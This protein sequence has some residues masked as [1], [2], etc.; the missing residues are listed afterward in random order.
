M[1]AV[2]GRRARRLFAAAEPYRLVPLGDILHRR[3]PGAFVGAIAE[4][5]R[6]TFAAGAPP[7]FVAF[8]YIDTARFFLRNYGFSHS[9]SFHQ[10]E[11]TNLFTASVMASLFYTANSRGGVEFSQAKQH[12]TP[13][14]E[15]RD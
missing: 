4:R 12:I 6:C 7:I 8:L 5:L 10:P 9:S 2:A 3:K 13:N 1:G 11:T 15:L 14:F